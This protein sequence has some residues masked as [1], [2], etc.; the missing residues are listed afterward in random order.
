MDISKTK[1]IIVIIT[2]VKPKFSFLGVRLIPSRQS[3][4]PITLSNRAKKVLAQ[5]CGFGTLCQELSLYDYNQ[6]TK[7]DLIFKT[8]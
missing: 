1:V 5:I 2:L 4:T 3:H 6:R 7:S 8:F